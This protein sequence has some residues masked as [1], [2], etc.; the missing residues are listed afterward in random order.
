M[1]VIVVVDTYLLTQFADPVI[2]HF[3]SRYGRYRENGTVVCSHQ[4]PDRVPYGVRVGAVCMEMQFV[5][6]A[7]QVVAHGEDYSLYSLV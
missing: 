5:A 1:W 3:G 7:L 2:R 6:T 4:R